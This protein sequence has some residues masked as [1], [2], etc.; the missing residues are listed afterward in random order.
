VTVPLGSYPSATKVPDR[1]SK[2]LL[3]LFMKRATVAAIEDVADRFRLVTLEGAALRGGTWKP[4]HKIQVAMGS[5]FVARTYTPVDWD[6]DA[7][8]TRILGYA[9]GDGP[10]SAWL[11]SL[12][13]GDECDIFGPRNSLDFGRT[14]SPLAFFGDGTSVGLAHA[15]T[16]SGRHAP[17][18]C[19]FEVGD[20]GSSGEVLARLGLEG[21]TL[22]AKRDDDAHVADMAAALGGPISAST[23]FVLTGKASTIQRLR[24]H[25]RREGLPATRILTKTYWAPGKQGL[26]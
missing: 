20:V 21:A 4:G 12:R 1:L 18:N 15:L 17:V 11:C 8:S 24:R 22:V 7:G 9:H 6:A 25:L 13:V 16:S 14:T 2:A 5:A 26:D 19:C 3:G 23:V 10:G